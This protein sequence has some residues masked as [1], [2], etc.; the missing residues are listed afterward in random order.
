VN[1]SASAASSSSAAAPT[2]V[3]DPSQTKKGPIVGGPNGAPRPGGTLGGPLPG[4]PLPGGAA[5]VRTGPLKPQGG[6]VQPSGNGE[7]I[8]VVPDPPAE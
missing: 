1:A 4:G 8:I 6:S 3:F 7:V 5:P 2:I